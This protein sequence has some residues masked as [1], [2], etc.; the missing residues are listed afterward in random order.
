MRRAQKKSS[1]SSSLTPPTLPRLIHIQQFSRWLLFNK[2]TDNQLGE[3]VSPAPSLIWIDPWFRKACWQRFC[4]WDESRKKV[5]R[6]VIPRR[7]STYC[8][9]FWQINALSLSLEETQK[10]EKWISDMKESALFAAFDFV[11]NWKVGCGNSR[12]INL[13]LIPREGNH[14]APSRSLGS[15]KLRLVIWG[16]PLVRPSDWVTREQ[17]THRK[18]KWNKAAL[19]RRLGE[20]LN[21]RKSHKQRH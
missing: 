8:S 21:S 17:K 20:P 13:N 11:F 18:P 12:W 6:S 3:R 15:S 5:S 1:E 19:N 9:A 4:G 7:I 14:P 10:E 2:L 16:L